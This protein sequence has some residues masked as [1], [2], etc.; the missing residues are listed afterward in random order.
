MRSV[1]N[2]KE[3]DLNCLVE[4]W[5]IMVWVQSELWSSGLAAVLFPDSA[6][7]FRKW[8]KTTPNKT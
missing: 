1:K 5:V 6:S 3:I 2:A 8:V 4:M 7:S